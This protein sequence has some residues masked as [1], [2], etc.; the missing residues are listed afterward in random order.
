MSAPPLASSLS[1]HSGNTPFSRPETPNVAQLHVGFVGLGNIGSAMAANL[2]KHGP[3]H[4]RGFPPILVWNR[5]RAKADGL[6]E[7]VGGHRASIADTIEE[8][9]LQCDVIIVNLADDD[10]VRVV[11][12]EFCDVLK[13]HSPAKRNKIFV[14]TS[15]I[16]P[17]LAGELDTWLSAIP[18]AQIITCPV[19][20]NPA[21]AANAQLLLIMSGPYQTKK[22]VSRIL[23]PSVGRKVIDLGGDLEK[24]LVYKL[25]ANSLILGTLEVMAE[26]LV[27]AEKS[28]IGSERV[29]DLIKDFFPAPS[30]INYADRM[31]HERLDGEGGGFAIDGGIKDATHIRRLSARYNCPM[32]A[33][34]VA[35]QHLVTARAL[36]TRLLAEGDGAVP[37]IMDWSG[38]IAGARV[39]A[40]LRGFDKRYDPSPIPDDDREEGSS[41]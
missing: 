35:H 10:A 4:I 8:V 19:L 24:A 1:G 22:I 34:D 9:V 14:E 26:S 20:G 16:Y 23:V 41:S 32:P 29:N 36:H 17:S 5:T 6:V 25:M 18:K 7:Q 21:A 3:D 40:G 33:I 2:A 28:G 31:V 15:T 12:R 13:R 27:F 30:M 38:I 11:Y 37:N 39:A